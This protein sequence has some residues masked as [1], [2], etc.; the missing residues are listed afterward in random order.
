MAFGGELLGRCYSQDLNTCITVDDLIT[1]YD[2]FPVTPTL[3][4][5]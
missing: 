4:Q 3:C 2:K 1:Y 5:I